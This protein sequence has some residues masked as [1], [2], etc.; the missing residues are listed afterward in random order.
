MAITD[1]G[2]NVQTTNYRATKNNNWLGVNTEAMECLDS[3]LGISLTLTANMS[4]NEGTKLYTTIKYE[5]PGSGESYY[6][7]IPSVGTPF[8]ADSGLRWSDFV[9]D[10][11][12]VNPDYVAKVALYDKTLSKDDALASNRAIFTMQ[13]VPEPATGTLSLLALAGLAARRRRK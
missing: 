11:L 5:I 12:K 3:P 13:N 8:M 6:E 7:T 4:N 2:K 9:M 1:A 10:T